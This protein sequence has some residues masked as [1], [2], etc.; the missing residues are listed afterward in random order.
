MKAAKVGG[1]LPEKAITWLEG[2]N[3]QSHAL[4][5]GERREAGEFNCSVAQSCPTLNNPMDC[6]PPGS[7]VHG[8]FQARI[9]EYI[10]IYFSR[11]SSQGSKPC[12]LHWKA[13]SLPPGKPV[14]VC[15]CVYYSTIEKN[16][17]LHF[18][19]TWMDLEGIMLSEISQTEKHRI[20]YDLT[21]MWNLKNKQK[22]VS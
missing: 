17:I 22:L 13:D 2:G 7:S 15:V 16:E 9:L 4:I 8:I 5:S 12:F 11:G 19:R 20:L 21:Y 6:R 3:I 18:E 14:C 10:A 1:W